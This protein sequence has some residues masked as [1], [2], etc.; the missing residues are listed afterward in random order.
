MHSE[1]TADNTTIATVSENRPET[2]SVNTLTEKQQKQHA[3][4]IAVELFTLRTAYPTQARNF[5]PDE[6]AA[7]NALWSEVFAGIDP[8]LLHLA[9]VRFVV[10]DRKAFF[11]TVGQIVGVVEQIM[12]EQ[13]G[14]EIL[15]CQQRKRQ[16]RGL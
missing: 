1:M 3:A 14:E 12:A 8:Q 15:A 10:A 2:Q 4:R 13:K 16:Q 9:I 11:P 5:S 6:I 7:I